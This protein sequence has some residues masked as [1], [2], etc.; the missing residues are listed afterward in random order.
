[1]ITSEE[2]EELLERINELECGVNDVRDGLYELYDKRIDNNTI[3][4]LNNFRRQLEIQG[5]MTTQ[6]DE[7]IENYIRFSNQGV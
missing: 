1:M 5:L 4:N 6:L 2:L 3:Y 7:F